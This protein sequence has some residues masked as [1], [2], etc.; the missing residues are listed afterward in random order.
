MLPASCTY[1]LCYLSSKTAE[2]QGQSRAGPS[3]PQESGLGHE[4][5]KWTSLGQ[6]LALSPEF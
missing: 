3:S 2:R 4:H 1:T 5:G 6:I